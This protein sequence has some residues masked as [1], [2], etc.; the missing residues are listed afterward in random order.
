[1]NNSNTV[2]TNTRKKMKA[3]Y[4]Y[5]DDSKRHLGIKDR[6][7]ETTQARF[8]GCLLSDTNSQSFTEKYPG[9]GRGQHSSLDRKVEQ[10][11]LH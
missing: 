6:E 3:K 7:R 10:Y 5:P 2:K 4:K 1:M 11:L 8:P 9:G